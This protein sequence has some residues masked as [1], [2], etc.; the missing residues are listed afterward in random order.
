MRDLSRDSESTRIVFGQIR[1]VISVFPDHRTTT[2]RILVSWLWRMIGFIIQSSFSSLRRSISDL[3]G[4]MSVQ[5]TVTL[6]SPTRA[7]TERCK[8]WSSRARAKPVMF[9]NPRRQ[10]IPIRPMDAS[11]PM[12]RPKPSGILSHRPSA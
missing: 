8:S 5:F 4:S 9:L 2:R 3:P 1:S 11:P 12:R 7:N 10:P 6:R